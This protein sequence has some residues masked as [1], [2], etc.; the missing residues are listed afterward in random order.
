MWYTSS[1]QSTLEQITVNKSLL[2]LVSACFIYGILP[3]ECFR[4]KSSF[5]FTLFEDILPTSLYIS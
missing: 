2:K 5:A 1:K 4:D 3:I